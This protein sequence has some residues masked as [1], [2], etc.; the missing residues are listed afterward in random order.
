MLTLVFLCFSLLFRK[1]SGTS[2][3][4]VLQGCAYDNSLT[5]TVMITPTSRD[6]VLIVVL[7]RFPSISISSRDLL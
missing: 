6:V 1:T 3:S 5:V 4:D 2:E 7:S